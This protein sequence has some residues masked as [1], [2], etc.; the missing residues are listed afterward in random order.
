MIVVSD[1]SPLNY[2]VLIRQEHVLPTLFG[3]VIA[4]PAVITELCRLKAPTEVRTWA[5]AP[6]GWLEVRT[7]AK[8]VSLSR[9]G[10]GEMEAIALAQE[11]SAD[12][13]LLDDRDG[14]A[15]ARRLGLFVT[16]TLGVLE[17]AAERT[18]LSLPNAVAAP[19]QTTFRGPDGLFEDLLRRDERRRFEGKSGE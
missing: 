11:L 7:P 10:P 3:R 9:L 5:S 16:G 18:L 19:R 12:A 14:V 2:L 8:V 17:M 13:L 15:A 6:P 1:T 4:P